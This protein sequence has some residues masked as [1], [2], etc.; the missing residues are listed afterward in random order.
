ML[1]ALQNY[2]LELLFNQVKTHWIF[3]AAVK[4]L[5]DNIDNFVL[6]VKNL[7]SVIKIEFIA[8]P[9]DD[10]LFIWLAIHKL[11]NNFILSTHIAICRSLTNLNLPHRERLTITI[12]K[13][14][15]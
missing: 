11:Y 13:A 9:I 5:D 4:T 12:S 10:R 2:T 1:A 3:L 14:C 8:V 15:G 6:I 7:I